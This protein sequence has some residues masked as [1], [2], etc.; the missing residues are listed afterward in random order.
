ML[1]GKMSLCRNKKGN[2]D[3]LLQYGRSRNENNMAWEFFS[4][5]KLGD[6]SQYISTYIADNA[7]GR[8]VDNIRLVSA[9]V[10]VAEIP[11][12]SYFE[13]VM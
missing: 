3:L 4:R 8:Q 13:A 10:V 6:T 12:A 9:G 2:Y 11:T 7:Q 5:N 1:N